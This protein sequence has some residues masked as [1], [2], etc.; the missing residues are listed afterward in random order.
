MDGVNF[1]LEQF[2][3]SGW[4]IC[5]SSSQ[6]VPK[7]CMTPDLSMKGFRNRRTRSNR[8][9]KNSSN[10]VSFTKRPWNSVAQRLTPFFPPGMVSLRTE[11]SLPKCFLME[12]ALPP[13]Y[14]CAKVTQLA[15]WLLLES[16]NQSAHF[17]RGK[18]KALKCEAWHSCQ[19]F[20]LASKV[21]G[22]VAGF[23]YLHTSVDNGE[24]TSRGKHLCFIFPSGTTCC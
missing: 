21:A 15:S 23:F 1:L 8:S 20:L 10:S 6:N 3:N 22:L 4:Q 16:R 24:M 11:L 17:C 5:F 2:P 9:L 12:K 13:S 18:G 14:S 19:L 7:K